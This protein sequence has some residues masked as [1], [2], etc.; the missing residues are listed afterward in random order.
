ADRGRRSHG[1]AGR[2]HR[3][4]RGAGAQSRSAAGA[5]RPH[6]PHD[7]GAPAPDRAGPHRREGEGLMSD[8]IW[9]VDDTPSRRFPLYTRGNIGEVFPVVVS[10]LTWTLYGGQAE[11]GW[12]DAWKKLDRKST[13]LNS[14]H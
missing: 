5:E 6:E 11:L 3:P 7:R 10:P 12:R 4:G 14:S 8:R 9:F 13:R 1:E 2:G